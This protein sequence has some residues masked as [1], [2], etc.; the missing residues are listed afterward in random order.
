SGLE[1]AVNELLANYEAKSA[2][3]IPYYCRVCKFQ[4]AS[5]E[6]L[7]AHRQTQL[8][9]EASTRERRV[10]FCKLCRKQFTS[11]PQ[12]REHVQGRAHKERLELVMRK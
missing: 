12:L 2:E 1:G 11:P 4:G 3:R 9:T 6:D 10:S 5:V 8:H 7:A